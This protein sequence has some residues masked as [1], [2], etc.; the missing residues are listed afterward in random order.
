MALQKLPFISDE[1]LCHAI[2]HVTDCLN[3]ATQF[4]ESVIENVQA[5]T[6]F[7]SSLFSNSIDPFAM[8]F[9]LEL[10]GSENWLQAEVSRQLYKTYE[11][12]IGEFHQIILGSVDGWEDLGI[13][14]ESKVDLYNCENSIYIELKN[15]YNTCNSDALAKVKDKLL[16]ILEESPNA[17]AYW[18]YIIPNRVKRSGSEP[19]KKQGKIIHSNLYKAWGAEVY[20]IVTGEKDSL[21]KLYH[22]LPDEIGKRLVGK[23][24]LTEITKC[25]TEECTSELN[26]IRKSV[27]SHS[28]IR[29]M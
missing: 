8:T 19:W 21:S 4:K 10:Y 3:D 22:V 5:D 15:K 29:R 26:K 9:G 27:F 11:Q 24:T 1:N 28:L 14:D 18:G 17:T 7:K 25:I 2:E 16:D 13:G 23:Q 12:K 6:I 20:N